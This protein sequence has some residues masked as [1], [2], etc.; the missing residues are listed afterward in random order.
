MR[1]G[2]I[3]EHYDDI[4]TEQAEQIAKILKKEL[5]DEDG[6]SDRKVREKVENEIGL[7]ADLADR[8]VWNERASIQISARVANYIH[9]LC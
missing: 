2:I 5:A 4:T 7:P 1:T 8:V 3:V 6:F 9:R